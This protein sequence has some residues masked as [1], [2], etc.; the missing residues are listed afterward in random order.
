MWRELTE[1]Q[2]KEHIKGGGVKCPCCGSIEIEGGFVDIGAGGKG[3]ASQTV[4]C[5]ECRA[6]W[7]DV[8]KLS[9]IRNP[10]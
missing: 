7:V 10:G 4:H 9:D 5:L 6:A 3:E 1:A 8:Y 2:V